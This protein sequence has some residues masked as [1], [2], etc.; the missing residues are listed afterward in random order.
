[1]QYSSIGGVWLWVRWGVAYSLHVVM[2]YRNFFL[3]LAVVSM[4]AE[5]MTRYA[6]IEN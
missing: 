1:M 4:T 6:F 3:R 2:Q 5:K